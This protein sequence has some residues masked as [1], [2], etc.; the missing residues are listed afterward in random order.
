INGLVGG[1]QARL[2]TPEAAPTPAPRVEADS[3]AAGSARPAQP[4]TARPA[5]ANPAPAPGRPR[6]SLPVRGALVPA[7]H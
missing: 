4:G 1:G 2:R 6:A 3:A 5:P 7:R